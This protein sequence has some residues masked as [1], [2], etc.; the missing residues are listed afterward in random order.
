MDGYNGKILRVDLSKGSSSVEQPEEDF[1]RRYVGGVGLVAY[2]LLKEQRAGIDPF[3]SENKVVFAIGPVTGVAVGGSGRNS[4]GA[5]SPL[6]NTFMTSE[7]GGYWGA[8]L[9]HA[10]YDVV[11][12]E[13]KAERPVYL[14]IQDGKAEIKDATHLWGK[15]VGET[16]EIMRQELH[17]SGVRTALIGPGGEKLVR[18]ACVVNDL[19][20][21]AGRGGIGAVMGSKNLKGIAVRG[22]NPLSVAEPTRISDAAKWY[23]G[24]V[25][26]LA[27]HKI[28]T[29]GGVINYNA[30]GGLPV[31]NF[32]QGTFSRVENL[33]PEYYMDQLGTKMSTCYAC[34]VRCKHEV[35]IKENYNLNFERY[36]G[37]GP[38]FEA[39]L[40]FGSFCGVDDIQAI[41]C[42]NE[43]CTAYGIDVISCGAT[44]ACAMECYQRG[45]LTK[46]ETDG[47]KLEFGNAKAMVKEVELICQRK[48]LGDILAEG[49]ARAT[50]KIGKEA[51]KYA[52]HVKGVEIP[53]HNPYFKPITG[54]GYALCPTG[55]DHMRN[56]PGVHLL[57]KPESLSQELYRSLGIL[58]ALPREDFSSPERI[59]IY[60]YAIL[61][62]T[63]LDCLGMCYFVGEGYG[64]NRIA[65]ITKGVTGWNTTVWELMKAGERAINLM[66]SFN[67]REG[68]TRD[69]DCI[70]HRFHEPL[71]NGPLKG[72][73][74]DIEEFERAKDRYYSMMHW[75]KNAKP[76]R[77]KLQELDIEWVA[78][79]L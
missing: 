2:Y 57:T 54:L 16:Q 55:A 10:G 59:R 69:D 39:L 12:V 44:I 13:G 62:R 5:K 1:Y 35:S 33:S 15:S 61:W 11:I 3:S 53:M 56:L 18:F 78:N 66:H 22:H 27:L 74:L 47:L 70:P 30:A 41:A 76:T 34:P 37:H 79:E 29:L 19:G 63:M 32:Q 65:E 50:Q 51:E 67:I 49:S 72:T 73:K 36:Q 64:P 21:F 8:E 38:E 48:G 7:V 31:R 40:S 4:I 43:L 25:G 6:S 42:A 20:H 17:D 24:I 26:S 58:N 60:I 23:R 46:K 14:W 75:H 71:A 28:G 68:F 45:L 77:A 52:M 9:K